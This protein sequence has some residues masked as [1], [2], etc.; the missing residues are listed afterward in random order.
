MSG[1]AKVSDVARK[2]PAGQVNERERRFVEHFM[3]T[4]NATKAAAQAGYSQKTASQIGYRLLRKVQIQRAIAERTET[5][6][7]VWTREAR[8]KFWTAV[9]SGAPRYETVAI[10]DRLKASEL[11]GRSQADFIDRHELDTGP[12]LVELLSE[13][14]SLASEESVRLEGMCPAAVQDECQRQHVGKCASMREHADRCADARWL[15]G[16]RGL[17]G[18][19]WRTNSERDGK[20]GLL[21]ELRGK[22]APDG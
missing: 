16:E 6:P 14:R 4:G 5:D 10:R 20:T 12:S 8:Q 7:A 3:A 17:S 18:D 13:S 15:A 22:V 9:A 1:T 2:R 19:R 11:L 21:C